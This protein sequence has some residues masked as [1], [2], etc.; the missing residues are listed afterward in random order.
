MTHPRAMP[1][2]P[3]AVRQVG[4]RGFGA[5]AALVVLVLLS[6]LGASIA[7]LGWTQQVSGAQDLNS[8]RAQQAANAGAEW[9]LYQALKGSW[10]AC[11][12]AS[13]TLDL[14]ATLGMV[15]TVTCN[16]TVYEEGQL[17]GPTL[18]ANG[19]PQYVPRSL[20]TY[21]IDAVACN[22]GTTCPKDALASGVAYVERRRQVQATDQ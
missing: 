17:Q 19:N 4:A 18:D 15:V 22:S 8:A 7:R 2:S 6:V 5:I 21:L 13:Q 9:G 20:R 12:S 16:S 11:A 1:I 14:N 3:A 10:S